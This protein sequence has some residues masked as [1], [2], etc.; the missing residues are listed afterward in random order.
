MIEG[1]GY[2]KPGSFPFNKSKESYTIWDIVM[3]NIDQL[4][5]SKELRYYLP[6]IWENHTD[7]N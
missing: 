2:Y 3:Y 4:Y 1:P 6:M 7:K 5:Q